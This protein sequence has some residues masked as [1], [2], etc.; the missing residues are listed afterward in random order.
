MD[1]SIAGEGAIPRIASLAQPFLDPPFAM[2]GTLLNDRYQMISVLGTGGFGQTYR[3]IDTQH[4]EQ[5]DCVVKQFKPIRDN[6]TFLDVARRLFRTEVS[7]L[8]KLGEHLQIPSFIDFFEIGQDFYLVQEFIDGHPLSE[9]FA[10]IG[11]LSETEAIALLKDV[12]GILT[13]V[14]ANHVIHRDIKPS[15]LV[16]RQVDRK[17]VLID[18]G[19]VKELHTQ[20]ITEPNPVGFTVGIG[21]QGYMPSEQLAGQPRFCSDLYALGV[22]IIQAVTGLQPTQLPINADTGEL[23]WQ[24]YAAIRPAFARLLERMVHYHFT[25]R[26]QSATEVLEALDHLSDAPTDTT[27]FLSPGL[28]DETIA[29]MPSDEAEDANWRDA[30][31]N[32]AGARASTDVLPLAGQ[33]VL[34]AKR[35]SLK[36]GWRTVGLAALI[37]TGLLTGIRQ[38]GGL[39][40]LELALYDQMMRSRPSL[41]PD[42]RLL[43]VGITEADLQTLQRAT[44]S[45]QDVATVI[46]TLLPYQPRV[47]GLDLHRELPQDPGHDRLMQQVRSPSSKV[48]VIT[49]LGETAATRVPPPA[50][51]SDDRVGF[52]DILVD[53]DGIVRRNL[54]FASI[55]SQSFYSFSLRLV[56][57]YLKPQ[58]IELQNTPNN[59]DQIQLGQATWTPLQPN[60]GGYHHLDAAGYQIL[61]NY[62]TAD[63]PARQITFTEVLKG[64]LKPEWVKDKVVLIGTVAASGK[65]VFYTPFSRSSDNP[66]M[67]GVELHAQMVS[68]LLSQ[69]L[70]GTPSF[71][72]LPNWAEILWIGSWALIGGSL[73][74]FSRRPIVVILAGTVVLIALGGTHWLIFLQ[75]GWLP[76]GGA[77]IATMVTGLSVIL[78][79]RSATKF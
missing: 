31:R 48:V 36:P 37:V 28:Q 4:P 59:P 69:A 23:I 74:G 73:V 53:P 20:L 5:A 41:G 9:E 52:N 39:Q 15:N 38:L 25:Q 11:R 76:A 55:G 61:L 66:Q 7:T 68:Q 6:A 46:Q 65:D 13:F 16:R 51:V 67:T 63:R 47:I 72:F 30:T 78:L 22:T 26:F 75:Q 60:S 50:G 71:W 45:D 32:E 14:H 35:F 18:F 70:D 64:R 21:T 33:P 79:N 40:P 1:R 24:D 54:M 29:H 62:R 49:K 77:A 56:L 10:T 8:A 27:A 57:S 12:L 42:P 3:A 58:G 17:M 2:L 43:L 19:A 44:P 34:P